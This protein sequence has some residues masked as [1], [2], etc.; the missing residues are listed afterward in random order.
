MCREVRLEGCLAGWL[1]ERKWEG[2]L[3]ARSTVFTCSE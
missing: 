2:C 3:P 1:G